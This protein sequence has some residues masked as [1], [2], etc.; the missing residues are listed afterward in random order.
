MTL[1]VT[2]EAGNVIQVLASPTKNIRRADTGDKDEIFQ[3]LLLTTVFFFLL[4]SFLVR[5]LAIFGM[6]GILVQG[7]W[8]LVLSL[9][10]LS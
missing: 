4:P 6:Q 1:L 10:G 5:G 2:I 7:V 3:S 9:N 8:G